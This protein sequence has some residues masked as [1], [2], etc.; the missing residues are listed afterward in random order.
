M[1]KLKHLVIIG[2]LFGAAL[3]PT[4][5]QTWGVIGL[6]GTG[7]GEGCTAGAGHLIV[8]NDAATGGLVAETGNIIA[9]MWI[10]DH[11]CDVD[12]IVI[13]LK[14]T[15]G[16]GTHIRAAIYA[17]SVGD[18]SGNMTGAPLA[19]SAEGTT[20]LADGN[21]ENITVSL[22][23]SVSIVQGTGYWIAIA[24]G[25]TSPEF[26]VLVSGPNY[27]CQWTSWTYSSS[28]ALKTVSSSSNWYYRI[29]S[30]AIS[31]E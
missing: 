30:Y 26:Y 27:Y 9:G 23:K 17:D 8:G 13:R 16:A 6:S 18:G 2:L 31:P 14:D 3:I 25:T 28:G 10:A 1:T 21:P 24:T 5:A 20:S 11:T 12:R 29:A 19:S 4:S 22:D 15:N 7:G